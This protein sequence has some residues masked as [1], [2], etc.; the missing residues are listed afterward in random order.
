MCGD[1]V[2]WEWA[3]STSTTNRR[4]AEVQAGAVRNPAKGY[5]ST[6][7]IQPVFVKFFIVLLVVHWVHLTRTRTRQIPVWESWSFQ[8]FLFGFQFSFWRSQQL[9][10]AFLPAFADCYPIDLAD[11]TAIDNITTTMI[12]GIISLSTSVPSTQSAIAPQQ[13]ALG[14]PHAKTHLSKRNHNISSQHCVLLLTAHCSSSRTA[15]CSSSTFNSRQV[16]DLIS[17]LELC[18][19]TPVVLSTLL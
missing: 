13:A 12:S 14:D 3:T 5:R 10:P 17:C 2:E 19:T 9:H 1:G 16:F 4:Q 18:E 8:V 11:L 15:K 7:Y 6:G